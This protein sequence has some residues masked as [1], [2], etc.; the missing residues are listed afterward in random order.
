MK[1]IG[2]LIISLI[3]VIVSACSQQ[4]EEASV[5]GESNAN[6]TTNITIS[7]KNWTEQ[8]LLV[9]IMG[10]LLEHH[11]DHKITLRDGLGSS[12][13]LVQ[14]LKDDDIQLFA[15]YTGTGLINI[16][17][18]ELEEG[19]SP[20]S[21]YEKTKKGYED[22]FG[23]TWLEPMGFSNTWTLI[24]TAEKAEEL[25]VKT[26]SD[27][28]PHTKDLVLG[29]DAQFMERQDGYQGLAK[30]YGIEG[31]KSNKEM[32]IGLAFNALAEGE[33][34]VLVGYATDG[35][36]PALGLVTLEDD[37]NYFPPY[38]AAPI[39]KTEFLEQYPEVGEVLNMLAGKIDAK[40]MSQL[41][42]KF[43]NDRMSEADV[44]R[45]FLLESSLIE[46]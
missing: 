18:Q 12:D 36:I 21:V 14:A 22:E 4:S 40:T 3:L 20:E 16:L 39:I 6:K 46:K 10:Q 19:D 15:D 43:D 28:V 30:K 9:H 42:S 25:N 29:S 7:G 27:L 35:R 11:T 17:G 34:D 1:K 44:A 5:S 13:V 37:K 32:D 24:L 41:N 23:F 8:I 33:V 26:F 31:F 38:D 2:I 45:E